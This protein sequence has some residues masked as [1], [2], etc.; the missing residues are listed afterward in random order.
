[1]K[2]LRHHLLTFWQSW[3]KEP[4]GI[5]I[6]GLAVYLVVYFSW[7]FA[8]SATTSANLI[9]ADCLYLLPPFMAMVFAA[10]AARSPALDRRTRRAWLIIACAF[11][12]TAIGEVYSVAIEIQTGD[13]PPFPSLADVL[14]ISFYPCML[15]GLLSFPFLRHNRSE[16]VQL[17][18]DVAVVMVGM[19]MLIWHILLQP[20]AAAS[21]PGTLEVILTMS[22]PVGDL[23]LLF[24]ITVVLIHKPP[25]G[26]RGALLILVTGLTILAIADII[27][28]YQQIHHEYEV[29]NWLDTAWTFVFFLEALS[30]QYQIWRAN[31]SNEHAPVLIQRSFS[32]LPYTGILF[33]YGLVVDVIGK[34]WSQ[35][36]AKLMLGAVVLTVLIVTRQIIAM[37]E[38]ERL[39]A[40]VVRSNELLL[41]LS[42]TDSLTG[43]A[44]R[45]AFEARLQ[46]ELHYT[47]RYGTPLSLILLDVDNFKSYNDTYG[48][49]DGD[50]VLKDVGLLLQQ[51]ARAADVVARHGG[52]EFVIL[53]PNTDA[54]EAVI[55]AERMREV[56]ATHEWPHR[57][58]TAS[59][60]VTTVIGQ[61]ASGDSLQLEADRALYHVKAVGRNGVYHYA[62][63]QVPELEA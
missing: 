27:Y 39:R 44:N 19:S 60:G 46:D 30:A 62:W 1:M 21:Y 18:L 35:P 31:H 56:I 17:W 41:A 59:F 28:V 12:A 45:R 42:L 8:N 2:V 4:G 22:Y 7:Y 9:I 37:R 51:Q 11:A 52:E 15:M 49:L 61:Q 34:N 6:V 63:D 16:R 43:A 32:M 58:I 24:G 13:I 14:F 54:S 36:L 57:T 25:P 3:C 47:Y 33:G 29:A 48:H 38:N 50:S 53:L 10:R 55:V 5:V 23:A 26:S 20:L 40:E